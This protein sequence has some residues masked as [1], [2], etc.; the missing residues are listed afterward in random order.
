MK[1]PRS[2]SV[3]RA[4]RFIFAASA[5]MAAAACAAVLGID[6]REL[7]GPTSG[8]EAG[9]SPIDQATDTPAMDAGVDGSVDA[10]VDASGKTCAKATCEDAG[11]A[12][13]SNTCTFACTG[14][15]CSMKT[16]VCPE[17]NDCALNC[18]SGGSCDTVKC[19]GG[20]SCTLLC[21]LDGT[22]KNVSCESQRCDFECLADTCKASPIS[23]DASVCVA[24]CA[25]AK[26]CD[27]GVDFRASDLCDI[28]CSGTPSCGGTVRCIAPTAM[29]DCTNGGCTAGKPTCFPGA[30]GSCSISCADTSC[31]AGYCCDSGT[32]LPIGCTFS[33]DASRMNT[34]P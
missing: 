10:G 4:A 8:A 15:S 9:D 24:N 11:G 18:S 33:G 12:C 27:K 16:V 6:D 28:K 5:V 29:I 30:T 17:G 31:G 2:K 19:R 7:I 26:S 34:C 25:G 20:L 1:H 3:A 23:C 21:A 13:S 14:A 22:C 32:S